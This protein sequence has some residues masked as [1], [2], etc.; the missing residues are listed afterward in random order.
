VPNALSRAKSLK[1]TT[2]L[3]SE[4]ISLYILSFYS[5]RL[6]EVLKTFR[7]AIFWESIK[8]AKCVQPFTIN[9]Y[10]NIELSNVIKVLNMIMN[11]IIVH[12]VIGFWQLS[13]P[14]Y[15]QYL[16]HFIPATLQQHPFLRAHLPHVQ[17]SG[18]PSGLVITIS[19]TNIFSLPS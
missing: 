15:L 3:L 16:Q 6:T 4:D 11:N 18:R 14:L 17:G 13:P 9:E 2:P 1:I 5:C 10:Y 19:G 12:S 7:I 8:K